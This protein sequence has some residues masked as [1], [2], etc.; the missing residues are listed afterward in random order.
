MTDKE[1]RELDAWIAEHVMGWTVMS[2]T[3]CD[4]KPEVKHG[5]QTGDV[6][7]NPVAPLPNYTID[8]AAAMMVLE[9]CCSRTALPILVGVSA[10]GFYCTTQSMDRIKSWVFS[11]TLPLAIALFAKQLFSK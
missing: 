6:D 3:L 7:I 5:R 2:E 4:P 10:G 9:K 11:D 8:P 1:L